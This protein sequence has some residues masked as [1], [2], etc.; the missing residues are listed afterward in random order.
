[1]LP[2]KTAFLSYAIAVLLSCL[3][4]VKAE[5]II[6]AAIIAVFLIVFSAGLFIYQTI[7]IFQPINR[8]G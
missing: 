8:P 2:D 7:N 1:M 6:M 5:N 4:A 3:H